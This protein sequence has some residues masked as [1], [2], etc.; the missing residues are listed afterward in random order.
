MIGNDIIDLKVAK[1]NSRWRE[2]RF[3][4]KLFTA[5]EQTLI[6]SGANRFENI[7]R[8]WSMKE[9]GYKIMSR[10]DK[11][12][13]FNPK[14]FKCDIKNATEGRVIFEN[15]RFSTRTEMHS[16]CLHTTAHS[17]SN[18]ISQV[19]QLNLADAQSQHF[20][21]HTHVRKAYSDLKQIP[22]N[23][24]SIAKDGVG[25][26]RLYVNDILQNEHLSITHHGLFGAL[27]IAY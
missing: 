15:K 17:N 25:V 22:Q 4:E 20:E 12:L 9:S 19:F 24:I 27:A 11:G 23:S 18:W 16:G 10:A 8:F 14:N 1:I 3:L 2:Q 13:R 6:L 21:M 7:W 26:P 5:E